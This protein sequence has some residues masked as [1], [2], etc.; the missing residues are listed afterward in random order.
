MLSI[1]QVRKLE[2]KEELL[3][4]LKERI[5]VRNQMNGALYW[6]IVNDECM[7]MAKKCLGLGADRQEI[8]KIFNGE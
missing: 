1:E 3:S 8:G 5:R 4:E 2:T 7:E 6:N